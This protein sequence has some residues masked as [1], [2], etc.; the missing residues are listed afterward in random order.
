MVTSILYHFRITGQLDS[1]WEDWFDGL[2]ITHMP[3]G[4][5]LLAGSLVDQAA[6]HGV[7]NKIRDLGLTLLVVQQVDSRDD[8][9][10]QT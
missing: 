6:M 7:L 2:T 5:T 8:T 3:D 9:G 4:T 1:S 10:E